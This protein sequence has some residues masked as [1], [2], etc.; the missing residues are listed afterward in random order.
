MKNSE[1]EKFIGRQEFNEAFDRAMDRAG[2]DLEAA[3]AGVAELEAGMPVDRVPGKIVEVKALLSR[4]ATTLR[5]G[6]LSGEIPHTGMAEFMVVVGE[7]AWDG[8]VL[9]SFSHRPVSNSEL[10]KRF[11]QKRPGSAILD[12]SGKRVN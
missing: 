7:T 9:I 11:G 10:E 5:E 12:P 1:D 8:A 4:L 6:F 3:K 2:P